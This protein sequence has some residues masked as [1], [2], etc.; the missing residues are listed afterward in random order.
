MPRSAD[1]IPA[2]AEQH[3]SDV[4]DD[5]V[6]Q[7]GLEER[8]GERRAALEEDVLAVAGEELVSASPGS[9]VRR[10]WCSALSSKIRERAG[11]SRRPIT[12]RSGWRGSGLV[13]GVAHGQLR[14][15]DLDGVGADQDRV[16]SARSRWVSLR[17]AA[18]V[19]HGWCRRPRRCGRRAVVANFQVTNG[20]WCSTAK[21]HTR[22]SSATP[23]ASRPV[24]DLD[25]GGAQGLRSPGGDR[26][27]VAWAKTTRATPALDQRL[28]R[29][30]R[31][32][33]CGCTARG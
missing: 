10:W 24:L 30:G 29:T 13:V 28:T 22:L 2:G 18:E 17:A 21:V 32:G 23:P 5:L 3:G 11:R 4:G 19:T 7:A 16:A 12:A 6:D 15:V 26:V 33:R 8:R 27:G 1:G 20:R 14:V 31:C 9:W 25:A